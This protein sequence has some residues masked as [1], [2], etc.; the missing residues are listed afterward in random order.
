MPLQLL[1]TSRENNVRESFT[2][3]QT[4]LAAVAQKGKKDDTAMGD[5]SQ[6]GLCPELPL[7]MDLPVPVLVPAEKDLPGTWL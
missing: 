6:G 1:L 2:V 5:S 3:L 4:R 7:Q